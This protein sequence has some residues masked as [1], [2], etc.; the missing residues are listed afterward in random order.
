[1]SVSSDIWQPKT[2]CLECCQKQYWIVIM[3]CDLAHRSLPASASVALSLGQWL[4]HSP[5]GHCVTADAVP[6][7]DRSKRKCSEAPSLSPQFW[8]ITCWHSFSWAL[9]RDALQWLQSK[10]LP[11]YPQGTL[12][13]RWYL[14]DWLLMLF[15]KKLFGFLLGENEW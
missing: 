1:M 12:L 14:K 3:I 9:K 8:V 11:P 15:E 10:L 7:L 6:G 2:S 13:L 5:P 4:R